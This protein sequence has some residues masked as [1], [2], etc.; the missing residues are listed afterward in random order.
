VGCGTP[1]RLLKL[2]ENDSLLLENTDLVVI[3]CEQNVKSQTIFSMPETRSDVAQLM[4]LFLDQFNTGK[5]KI[6]FV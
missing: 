3:D 5:T 2:V 6:C 4:A 1:N